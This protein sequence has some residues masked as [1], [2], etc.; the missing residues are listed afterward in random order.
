MG[1]RHSGDGPPGRRRAHPGGPV[2]G[3]RPADPGTALEAW[4]GTALRPD[5]AGLDPEAER[6][7]VAAFRAARDAG[8]HR[9]RT[10]RRD[11][12]RP[13]APRRARF[14]V[15]ASLS[16]FLASVALG[17]LAVAAIASAGAPAL[18]GDEPGR[19]APHPTTDTSERP[20]SVPAPEP[21]GPRPATS[22]APASPAPT[23]PAATESAAAHAHPDRPAT[24]KD[25]LAHCRAYEQVKDRGKALNST[26]WQR[27]VTAA[28][29][30][31]KVAAYCAGRLAA[32]TAAAEEPG[33]ER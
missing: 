3:P 29:G 20:A 28:G 15:T 32:A 22:P 14:S 5:G 31:E 19:P 26:A 24:A 25:T 30:A 17:G 18:R 7:A 33:A 23:D 27:L 16:A 11:D 13:R 10:R 12:W 21:S 2:P 8:A 4:F 9:A 6:R 1:E